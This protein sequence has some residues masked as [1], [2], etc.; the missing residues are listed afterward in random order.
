MGRTNWDNLEDREILKA[1]WE[2]ELSPAET[3]CVSHN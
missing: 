1:T 2:V 3:G